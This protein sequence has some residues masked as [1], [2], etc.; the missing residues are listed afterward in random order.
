[1]SGED[2][3]CKITASSIQLRC[4]SSPSFL[5]SQSNPRTENSTNYT[6][7][8][9]I[10]QTPESSTHYRQ[11]LQPQSPQPHYADAYTRLA[12]GP[13]PTINIPQTTL[14]SHNH[15]KLLSSTT[16]SL[17]LACSS[18][19]IQL[20]SLHPPKMAHTSTFTEVELKSIYDFALDLGRRA[21]AILLE[22]VEKRTAPR[23]NR[24][25]G[26]EEEVEKMNAVDIVTQTDLG[27]L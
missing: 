19:P 17:N 6:R 15:Q 8:T 11:N 25:T 9:V 14:H 10:S 27:T 16:R 22:G 3:H 24:E 26:K 7:S 4:S 5:T 23:E 1:M 18:N 13:S 21:G 2:L 12:S 20:T